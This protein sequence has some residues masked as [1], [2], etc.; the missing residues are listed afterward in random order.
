MEVDFLT[1]QVLHRLGTCS[2]FQGFQYIVY[3]MKL[4]RKDRDYL[5]YVTKS[6]YIDIAKEFV[7]TKNRRIW[8][9]NPFLSFAVKVVYHILREENKG[10][11][12]TKSEKTLQYL[13]FF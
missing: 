5:R 13:F 11:K 4:I 9:Y 7:T 3:A 8:F 12:Y 2:N 6:L 1:T 10:Y